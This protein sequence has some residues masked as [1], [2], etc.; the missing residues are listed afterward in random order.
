VLKAFF[1]I[2]AALSLFLTGQPLTIHP[3]ASSAVIGSQIGDDTMA[4]P[5]PPAVQD[6]LKKLRKTGGHRVVHADGKTYVVVGAGQRPTGGYRLTVD[7]VK[8]TSKNVFEVRVREHKPAPG[9]LKTQVI[10]FPTLVVEL[11]HE[12]ATVK[13]NMLR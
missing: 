2:F 3:T 6:T 10:S 9:S 12:K 13:L 1:G 11:P 8:Q 7:G 4:A 5:Y